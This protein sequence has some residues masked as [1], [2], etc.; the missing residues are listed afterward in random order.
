MVVLLQ[1]PLPALEALDLRFNKK[2]YSQSLADLLHA[3]LPGVAVQITV[4]SPS[5]PGAFVGRLRQH[6]L[7]LHAEAA[8]AAASW[9]RRSHRPAAAAA[10][11]ESWII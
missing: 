4:T 6:A 9:P 7:P 5:P 8:H 10:A 2:C 3:E 11:A 1:P